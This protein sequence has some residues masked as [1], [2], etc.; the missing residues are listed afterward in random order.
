[1]D[2]ETSW[3]IHPFSH[4][5]TPFSYC[6][7]MLF[8]FFHLWQSQGC[9]L[10]SVLWSTPTFAYKK[11]KP[12]LLDWPDLQSTSQLQQNIGLQRERESERVQLVLYLLIKPYVHWY[13]PLYGLRLVSYMTLPVSACTA[14]AAACQMS[15]V[16][17]SC[18]PGEKRFQSFQLQSFS[19]SQWLG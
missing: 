15:A 13:P 17:H 7:F 3:Q 19:V 9:S 12:G 6:L 11:G 16:S 1:M 2:V 18:I 8:C 4:S 14:C 10:P 5:E